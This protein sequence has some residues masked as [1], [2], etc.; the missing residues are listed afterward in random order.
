MS[1][2]KI[3]DDLV[4]NTTDYTTCLKSTLQRM[5]NEGDMVAAAELMQRYDYE[6]GVERERRPWGVITRRKAPEGA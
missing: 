5:A 2:I 3:H 6:D 4:V 1:L